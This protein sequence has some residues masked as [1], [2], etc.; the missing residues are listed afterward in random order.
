MEVVQDKGP[1]PI[2]LT[3]RDRVVILILFPLQVFLFL[4]S[5][6]FL[7]NYFAYIP[8]PHFI[9][10]PTLLVSPFTKPSY[11][12]NGLMY[13]L[14]FV[15]H[16]LMALVIFK[17]KGQRIWNK[18]PLYERYIYNIVSGLVLIW[19]YSNVRPVTG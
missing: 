7:F 13:T 4:F 9:S 10:G 2:E 6:A 14:F 16:I 8:L 19:V 18:F 11:L 3:G 5:F 1:S 12:Y 15:Q 17:I